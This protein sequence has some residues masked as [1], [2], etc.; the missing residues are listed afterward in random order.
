MISKYTIITSSK[1]IA[2]FTMLN[3]LKNEIEFEDY[4]SLNDHSKLEIDKN[5]EVR[6]FDSKIIFLKSKK[7]HN[8]NLVV[9]DEELIHLKNIEKSE[10]QNSALIFLSKHASKSKIP[11]LTSHFTGNFSIDNSLGGT[12]FEIGVA[13]PS[14]QKGFMKN[15]YSMKNSLPKYDLTIEASHH[16]PTSSSKP[17]LFI[18]IGSS[19]EEWSNKKTAKLVCDCL[20]QTIQNVSEK[21]NVE[22]SEIA[23]GLGGNHYPQ[24]FNNLILTSNIAFASIASKHNLRFISN[25]MLEQMKGK[26]IEKVT[27]IYIDKK[28]LG[29]EK[30]RILSLL[31]TQELET[32]YV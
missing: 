3:Y 11:A 21:A 4:Y 15:L 5:Q 22:E 30:D 17:I 8:L 27:S 1:D 6:T 9:T 32:K 31:R 24:K 13:C 18:E 19:E 2:S 16:G 20:I 14:F 23:I 7:Y 26:S 10:F 29:S 25:E 12:P 28:G